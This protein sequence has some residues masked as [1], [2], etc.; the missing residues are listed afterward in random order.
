MQVQLI[1]KSD[2]ESSL[3]VTL[4]VLIFEVVEKDFVDF[5]KTSEDK[6]SL[7]ERNGKIRTQNMASALPPFPRI[8]FT[9]LEPIS[10]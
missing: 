1:N 6:K 8:V 3:A 4:C 9:I 2:W 7:K 5:A 10:L